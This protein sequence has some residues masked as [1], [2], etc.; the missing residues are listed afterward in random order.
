MMKGFVLSA[1]TTKETYCLKPHKYRE[2]FGLLKAK[3]PLIPFFVD[4]KD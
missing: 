2:Q 3:E 1:A 4:R